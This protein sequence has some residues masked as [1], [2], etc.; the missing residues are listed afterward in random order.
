MGIFDPKGST[1]KLL[2]LC[3]GRFV[4]FWVG[5][6]AVLLFFEHGGRAFAISGLNNR[7]LTQSKLI[8]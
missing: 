3:L 7:R 4:V 2:L 1:S 5:L 6:V 8:C